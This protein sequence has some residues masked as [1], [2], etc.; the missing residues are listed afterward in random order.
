MATIQPKGENTRKAEKLI[1]LERLEDEEK[2]I[3]LFIQGAALGCSQL[4]NQKNYSKI[5]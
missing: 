1:S 5:S 4:P 2:I 3:D